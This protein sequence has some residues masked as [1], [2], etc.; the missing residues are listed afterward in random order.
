MNFCN[1]AITCQSL[2]IRAD[3]YRNEMPHPADWMEE[4][5]PGA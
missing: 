4:N 1:S 2:K 3:K 5:V